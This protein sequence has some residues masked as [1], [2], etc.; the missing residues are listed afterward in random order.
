METRFN[1]AD[2]DVPVVSRSGA[3]RALTSGQ[4]PRRTIYFVC[5]GSERRM[6]QDT[7]SLIRGHWPVSLRMLLL[8]CW[9]RMQKCRQIRFVDGYER[10]TL[11]RNWRVRERNSLPAPPEQN[12]SAFK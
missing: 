10:S 7:L 5:F 3:L 6:A 2:D 4:R 1:G 12:F 9:D 8:K 11:G